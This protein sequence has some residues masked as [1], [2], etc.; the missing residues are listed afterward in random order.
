MSDPFTIDN[1]PPQLIAEGVKQQGGEN[2]IRLTAKDALSWIQKAEYSVNGAEWT[3]LNPLGQASD[4][5]QLS[6]ELHIP[7]P[8]GGA[9]QVVAIR[10]FDDNDNQAVTRFVVH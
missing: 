2:V 4:S 10:V 8:Q 5:E 6:Y 1:T 7:R 9:E 3:L